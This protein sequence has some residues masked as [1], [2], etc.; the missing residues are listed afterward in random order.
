MS[1]EILVSWLREQQPKLETILLTSAEEYYNNYSTNPTFAYDAKK[2]GE[3]MW[4]LAHGG[5]L[6]YDRPT[7][8][9]N[10][11][12]WYHPKRINT[13][14]R[15]FTDLIYDARNENAIEI[16]DLGAGTGAVLWAV[17]LVV[18][19][20][21]TLRM[22][23]PKIRVINVDTSAFMIIYNYDFLWKNFVREFPHAEEISKQDD[24]R[25]NSWSNLDESNCT[26]IWLC[27]SYL[28]D[29]SENSQAIADE[30][31]AIVTR[32]K[33]NKVLLLSALRKKVYVDAVANIIQALNY[34]GYNSILTNQIF[35]GRLTRLYE[36]RNRISQQHSLN[37]T[38]IPQWNIDSLYG[39]ILVN[40]I[41][42]LGFDF[43]IVNLF[44]Q[45]ERNRAL[46]K[47]T[48]QQEDAATV[49]N[50]PTL[51]IGPAGCGKSV[52]LTQKIRNLVHSTRVG[53]DY[54]PTLKILVSTF[55]KGLVRYLGDWVE[56]LLEPNKFTRIF[57][58]DIYGRRSDHSYFRFANSQRTNI[59]VMHFDLLPRR[60]GGI[61][62][63]N[64]TSNGGGIE[65]FHFNKMTTAINTYVTANNINRNEFPTILNAEFLLDEYQ[66]V[67]YGFEC[68]NVGEYQT[69]ER[70]GRGNTPQLRYN[71]RRRRII[72]DII[73]I[74]LKDL[75]NNRLESF[76][77]RRHRF[78]KKLRA[79]GYQN[80]F[81]HIIV[82]EFQDCTKADYEIFY[83]MLQYSNNLTLAGDIAQSINLGSALH[84]PRADD[85]RRFEKKRLE[86]SFRLPF[87]VSECIKPFSEIINQKFGEREGIQ[88]DIINPYKGAPPGSRP[89]FVFAQDT[90]TAA[91][92]IKD[93]FFAYQKALKLDKVTIYE[94]DTQLN[95]ALLQSQTPTETEI[96]LRTKGLEKNCVVWSTR[97]SVD[98]TTEKEEFVY[99]IITRTVSLLIVVVFPDIQQDYI[100]IIK[101]FVPERVICWDLE[102]E[103]KY[104]EIRQNVNAIV[105]QEDTDNT[106]D[107]QPANEE[108]ID[109]LIV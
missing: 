47:L 79:Y 69:I 57:D 94:R 49:N 56:Q 52:V 77:I 7:I 42:Q 33:P 74:Y 37:L 20:L 62:T 5:D 22:P 2:T 104:Q 83:Q 96:I 23:C 101:T 1:K 81:S 78:I 48:P 80:K 14:L 32:Y 10:Y 40:N 60:L 18:S 63:L 28:F 97:I 64:I 35:S 44:I 75:H 86:G 25:L 55:N 87:R 107:N 84:I 61:R 53:N 103:T 76:I 46:I 59:T 67:I 26:N 19:G 4:L 15:Y 39:R 106:E 100:N 71:S 13:F 31:N 70:T 38:G 21:K 34:G 30:F 82:D 3:E 16:F 98:T 108:N 95:T 91:T 8:A 41:P 99:T 50:R 54:S 58:T 17:G 24:Y 12:L 73:I 89:I 27:A 90:N 11:S 92:K 93:I 102:S 43:N 109:T 51:V 45:P 105:A 66:R 6:C 29:H 72:W 65:E 9:F 36:F 88:A 85:Q 68:N